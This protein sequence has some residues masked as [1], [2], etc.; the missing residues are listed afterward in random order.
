MR[1]K[2]PTATKRFIDDCCL[3]AELSI[4]GRGTSPQCVWRRYA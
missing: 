3:T 1:D 2:L 4:S